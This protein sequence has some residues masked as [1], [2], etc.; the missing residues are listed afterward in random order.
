MNKANTHRTRAAALAVRFSGEFSRGGQSPFRLHLRLSGLLG[1]LLDRQGGGIFKKY[2]LDTELI[3]INGSTRG[4]QSLIAGEID[5]AG[6]V[7][8]SAINGSLAGGDIAIVD[9]LVN[10]LPYYI[11]GK[12]DIKSPEDLKGRAACNAHSR[13]VG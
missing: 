3:F 8:T 11:I 5:F 1:S 10:T 7:G 4:V 13:D 6:A 9:S 12:A 2:G